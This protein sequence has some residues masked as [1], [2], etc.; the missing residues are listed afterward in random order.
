MTTKINRIHWIYK[1]RH[2][3]PTCRWIY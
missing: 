1:D 2:A 3:T